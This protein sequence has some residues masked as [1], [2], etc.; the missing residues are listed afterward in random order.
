MIQPICARGF[1]G[2]TSRFT[3]RKTPPRAE[4]QI[5]P[6]VAGKEPD[7]QHDG[8]GVR[9]SERPPEFEPFS[10]GGR[11]KALCIDAVGRQHHRFR[12]AARFTIALAEGRADAEH[13]VGRH[14]RPVGHPAETPYRGRL[15][16]ARR[17]E[18]Q[19]QGLPEPPRQDCRGNILLR[20]AVDVHHVA[21]PAGRQQAR[22]EPQR[23]PDFRQAVP[24]VEDD[25]VH[26]HSV[27]DFSGGER[28]IDRRRDHRA[29]D[30]AAKRRGDGTA[31]H[32][33]GA[34][35]RVVRTGH[36]QHADLSGCGVGR[37]HESARREAAPSSG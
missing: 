33:G 6:L 31:L 12:G 37:R 20:H 1:F 17:V 10:A 15:V 27:D 25:A 13:Q 30:A 34:D 4:Q 28:G 2:G 23:C 24:P 14:E 8:L 3:W 26:R 7:E 35:L 5:R 11:T 29:L 19:H 18:R 21:A 32:A 36:E 9:P 22:D 16:L